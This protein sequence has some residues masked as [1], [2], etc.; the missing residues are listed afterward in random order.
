MTHCSELSRAGG[1]A[2]PGTAPLATIWVVVEHP[3]GW[4][5]APLARAGSGVRVLM[6]RAGRDRSPQ[7]GRAARVWV[8]HLDP[9]PT[10][11]VGTVADPAEVAGWDLAGMA[12]GALRGWGHPDPDPL[13]LVCANGRRDRCCG[14]HGGRLAQHLQAG[15]GGDRVLTSTHLGGHRFAPTA[16]VLPTGA[17]HGRLSA[18]AAADLLPLARSGSTAAA[19]LRGFSTHTAV[20]QVAEAHARRVSGHT[21]GL[22]LEVRTLS[23]DGP[24]ARVRVWLPGGLGALDVRVLAEPARAVLSCGRPAEATTRWHVVGHAAAPRA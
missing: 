22:P 3:T 4:A 8:A 7:P 23:E 9:E 21:G 11:R 13:L 15:Q 12:A 19:S 6:A 10:L 18:D 17:L 14:L 5:D 2:M 20:Q 1:E 24:E 16:L